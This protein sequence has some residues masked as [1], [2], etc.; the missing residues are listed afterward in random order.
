M[1][2][3][4]SAPRV[5]FVIPVK[6][7]ARRLR[8][9]LASIR[10][11]Q[12][13]TA[14]FEI[15]VADNGSTDETPDVARAAGARVFSW[16]GPRV[17]ELRNRGAA[18]ARGG[19]LAFVDAD[20]EIASGWI[21]AAVEALSREKTG[22]AGALY[23]APNPGTW[24][25]RLYGALRGRTRGSS[26]V[27]WLG[28]GNLAVKREVFQAIGGFDA[29]LEACEDVDFCQRL[30]GAGWRLVG[31][32][33]LESVHLGDPPT[34]AA[35]FRAE[36][37]RGRDNLR[38]SL[39]GPLTIGD[40]PS[41]MIPIIDLLA[42]LTML[43]AIALWPLVGARLLTVAL[44]NLLIVVLLSCLRAARIVTRAGR[45]GPLTILQAF[46][47]AFTYDIARAAALVTRASH[48]RRAPQGPSAAGAP[49]A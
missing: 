39:R 5:S 43:V 20:H 47:V 22:A 46:L 6:N 26:D 32:E 40:L 31:D 8:D 44:A 37:W 4:T 24:V 36:R 41:L 34:L 11:N 12:Y 17:S 38:V 18:E 27:L 19:I 21:T 2:H 16:P 15:V 1:S 29:S 9:C 30:R 14:A 48:H 23:T 45:L 25:Q 3:T 10:R 42:A 7:D 49:A 33:R 13:E 28:S 35:L